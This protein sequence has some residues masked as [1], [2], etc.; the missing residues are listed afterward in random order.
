M[1]V[2]ESFKN[3]ATKAQIAVHLAEE[4]IR[5]HQAARKGRENE[6]WDAA[7]SDRMQRLG[8]LM[9]GP[10]KNAVIPIVLKHY[11]QMAPLIDRKVGI[12]T[13]LP[14]ER[15]ITGLVVGVDGTEYKFGASADPNATLVFGARVFFRVADDGWAHD[16][17]VLEANPSPEPQGQ[18]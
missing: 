12:V 11:P 9:V 16:I 4:T 3:P 6:P 7:D 2:F 5:E 10:H 15:S 13:G 1:K 14:G 18:A 17:Q 8:A